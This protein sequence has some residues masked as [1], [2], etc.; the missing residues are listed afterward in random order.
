MNSAN[1]HKGVPSFHFY[2]LNKFRIHNL[3]E[4][5]PTQCPPGILD[6][7]LE[8]QVKLKKYSTVSKM[9]GLLT[10]KSAV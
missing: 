5:S 2:I 6:I 7:C 3:K 4:P 9:L 8:D 1:I 10:G